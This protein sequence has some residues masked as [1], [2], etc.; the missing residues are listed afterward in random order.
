LA[1]ARVAAWAA[2][3]DAS[4]AAW[5]DARD[6]ERR[7]QLDRLCCWLSEQEPQDWPLFEEGRA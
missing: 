5:A 7:W 3:S 6:A 1:A 2:A 4:Y